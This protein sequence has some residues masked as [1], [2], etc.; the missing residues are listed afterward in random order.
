MSTIGE[1]RDVIIWLTYDDRVHQCINI[2]I[3]DIPEAYGVFLR[4]DWSSKLQGYFAIDWSHLWLMHKG[5]NNL[6]RLLLE[7]YMKHN[8]TPFNGENESLAFAK[9]MFNN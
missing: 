2:V 7:R 4:R 5:R 9:L 6:I 3:V 8:V 1:L